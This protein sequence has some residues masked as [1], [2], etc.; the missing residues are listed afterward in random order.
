MIFVSLE[1][2]ELG[3]QFHQFRPVLTT[4]TGSSKPVFLQSLILKFHSG[5]AFFQSWDW[6]FTHYW[7]GHLRLNNQ[8]IEYKLFWQLDYF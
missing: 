4:K 7:E 1:R 6:T 2:G 8:I 5:P 3:L